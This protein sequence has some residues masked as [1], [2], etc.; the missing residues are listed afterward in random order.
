MK[1]YI[2]RLLL[3]INLGSE[4]ETSMVAGSLLDDNNFHSVV[5]SRDRR[6]VIVSIDHHI[7]RGLIQGEFLNLDLDKAIFIGG[8]PY[9]GEGLITHENFTGCIDNMY[10]NQTSVG[11][12][13]GMSF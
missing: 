9:E 6:D 2:F 1:F 12:F 5:I 13:E 4:V 8:V 10:I 7:T 11:K 3:S